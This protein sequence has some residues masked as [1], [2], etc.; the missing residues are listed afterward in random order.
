[1]V[2]SAVASLR[3]SFIPC[4][5][6]SV[7]QPVQIGMLGYPAPLAVV[8]PALLELASRNIHAVRHMCSLTDIF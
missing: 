2:S 5:I 6:P 8:M 1:M 7:S 3:L 4:V